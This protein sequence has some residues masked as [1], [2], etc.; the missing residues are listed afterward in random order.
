MP[1]PTS[2]L[3]LTGLIG[4]VFLSSGL[5]VAKEEEKKT[6]PPPI[7]ALLVTGGCSHDYTARKEIIVQGIRE[8]VKRQI[9]WK[10]HHEGDGESD[11]RIPLFESPAWAEGYDIVVHDYCFPRV[12]DPAYI[13]RI[14]APHRA[15]LPAV[16]I[17]GTMHS[18]RIA[19]DRWFDFCG[20]T[21]RGH[22]RDHAIVIEPLAKEN[23]I[24]KGMVPWPV[25][26]GELYRIEKL[27]AGVTAL[28]Q[29]A[30]LG[31]ENHVNTWTHL[32]GPANTRVFAT[33]IGNE[34]STL[35]TPTYLDLIARGFLWALGSLSD[36]AFVPIAPAQSLHGL[37]LAVPE[38]V[39]P[40]PGPNRASGGQASALSGGETVKT[41]AGKAIDGDWRTYWE[42][43]DVGPSS[44]QVALPQREQVGAVALTWK[45]DA[46]GSFLLEGSDDL[47]AWKEL[48]RVSGSADRSLHQVLAVEPVAVRY[49]RLSIF[50][51]PLR[52]IPGLREFGAF[53]SLDEVPSAFLENPS[54]ASSQANT[55]LTPGKSGFARTLRLAPG[56]SLEAAVPL[57]SG[58]VP[59][60]LIPTAAGKAFLL[61]EAGAGDRGRSVCSLT[62]Q[63][64]GSM[65]VGEFLKTLDPAGGIAW[66]G[67]WIYTFSGGSLNAYRDTKGGGVADERF[68]VGQ[69]F[70]LPTSMP[71]AAHDVT[72]SQLRLDLDGWFYALVEA[73]EASLVYNSRRESVLLPRR[74]LVRFRRNGSEFSVLA[75][76]DVP[77]DTF[78]RET[79]GSFS[80]RRQGQRDGEANPEVFLSSPL[81][82]R[83]GRQDDSLLWPPSERTDPRWSQ[84]RQVIAGDR[85]FYRAD[86]NSEAGEVGIPGIREIARIEGL[87]IAED[88][89]PRLWFAASD[90]EKYTVAILK[91]ADKSAGPPVEWDVVKAEDLFLLRYLASH[92]PAVRREVVFE[93]LRRKRN[94]VPDL[95]SLLTG[96]PA[97]EA[98]EPV[99]SA[100]SGLDRNRGLNATLEV[101]RSQ[102]PEN[103]VLAFRYLGDYPGMADHPVF[104]ELTKSTV[105]AVTSAILAAILRTG[106]DLEGLDRLVLNFTAHPDPALAATARAFL[107][108]R[109]SVFDCF[110]ALDDPARESDW[111]GAFEVLSSIYRP[112]VAEGI[113]LRLEKTGSAK[114]R[115]LGLEALCRL[116]YREGLSGELWEGTRIVDLFL[117]ASLEDRRVDRPAL[118]S[119][120]RIAGL[121]TPDPATLAGL[122]GDSIPLEGL[123]IET[124]LGSAG[125][126]SAGT[127]SWLGT[128]AKSDNR[129][130]DLRLRAASLFVQYAG[131]KEYQRCFNET[132]RRESVP[133][134][135]GLESLVLKRWLLREDHPANLSWLV[136]Q[137]RGSDEAKGKLA[138][139]TLLSQMDRIETSK[140]DKERIE[141]AL[142][143]VRKTGEGSPFLRLITVLSESGYSGAGDILSAARAS[144]SEAIRMAAVTA[145]VARSLDPV[146]GLPLGPKIAGMD[147]A[148]LV[149]QV[150]AQAPAIAEGRLLFRRL[151]C[152][153]CHNIHGEGPSAGP[154]LASS[155]KNMATVDLVEAILTPSKKI[156][157]GFEAYLFE[158]KDGRRL[159]GFIESRDATTLSAS[160][161]A[162]NSFKVASA[163][164]HFE[165]PDG[166]TTMHCDAAAALSIRDFASLLQYLRSLVSP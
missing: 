161:S 70:T 128:I 63:P 138:W 90:G 98:I 39:L 8:R 61:L 5:L 160:D 12:I 46:P 109:E 71:E 65:K 78:R 56:W 20:A 34:T 59:I 2:Q 163:D 126:V 52:V 1:L 135:T 125:P 49:L 89:G 164:I 104:D 76:L 106:T 165:W 75:R 122:A 88:D 131:P 15:G 72:F 58:A 144:S 35:L 42:A 43:A 148:E 105:P 141:A 50:E 103:Q 73:K 17:H 32:Y 54:P 143:E 66:D 137:A 146:T 94:P 153:A 100:L 21:S 33:T 157:P 107:I 129:D 68:R 11:V 121:P 132:A 26:N 47:R 166:G 27:H 111:P 117:K 102:N 23:P 162:G 25:R 158:L 154:D 92:S 45:E 41:G 113:V 7:K 133:S 18:F 19:D 120:M 101:A 159:R 83:F 110:V 123:A 30:T 96:E 112:T 79:G 134:L 57:A 16:L 145:A 119:A 53:A 127:L 4:L 87:K 13:D 150:E 37:S 60:Q 14:L 64:D 115:R 142:A 69:V 74:G 28:T 139:Q 44:W 155:V 24:L 95:E 82:T 77:L 156:R 67:E 36:E 97:T 140:A 10:V 81:F 48:A 93:I 152:D 116:Y 108:A 40:E 147:S 84:V 9:E 85:L 62:P 151:D 3:L 118:L 80:L 136:E 6:E 149:K 86:T 124:L 130:G 29:S 114:L 55:L 91:R 38:V 31:G 51:T 99:L 22:E